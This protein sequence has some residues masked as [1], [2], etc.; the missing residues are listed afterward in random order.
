MRAS[1]YRS[2][3]AFAPDLDTFRSTHGSTIAA[4]MLLLGFQ[5]EL[6]LNET[7]ILWNQEP[8]RST[9]I[10]HQSRSQDEGE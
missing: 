8:F 7:G 2:Q 6:Q 4:R 3:S 5:L 10:P 9:R 1:P